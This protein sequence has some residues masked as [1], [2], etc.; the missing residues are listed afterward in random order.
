MYKITDNELFLSNT[1]NRDNLQENDRIIQR[2]FG[3]K[4]LIQLYLLLCFEIKS[5]KGRTKQNGRKKTEL[6]KME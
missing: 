5:N 3:F 6:L 2:R 1:F 4:M